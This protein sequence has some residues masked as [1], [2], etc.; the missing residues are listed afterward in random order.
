[1]FKL[2]RFLLPALTDA[3]I[4]RF[5]GGGSDA[6]AQTTTVTSN[7]PEYA[8]PYFE[9]LLGQ[10]EA[11]TGSSNPYTPY[12]GLGAG[13]NRVAGMT[14]QQQ[15]AMQG[16]QNLYNQGTTAAMQTGQSALDS[17]I[18]GT[19]GFQYT[20]TQMGYQNI[21][22]GQLGPQLSGANAAQV[23]AFMSPY[24]QQVVDVEKAAAA[25]D[26]QLAQQGRNAQAVRAGAFGG[27]R[28]AVADAEAQRGLMSQLQSIQAKG[29]QDAFSQAQQALQAERG[30]LMQAGTT[31]LQ[32]S[33]QAAQA[34]QQAYQQAQAAQEQSQQFG[35]TSG[36]QAMQQLGGLGVQLGAMGTQQQQDALALAQAQYGMGQQ[37]QQLTQQQYANAYQ[38]Y[39][40]KLNYPYKQLGFMSDILHG[41]QGVGSASQVY[42]AP[43]STAS[44]VASLGL[45]A[46]GLSSLFGS[47]TGKAGGGKIKK[48]NALKKGRLPAMGM[49]LAQ[50]GLYKALKG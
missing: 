50:A 25:R 47:P 33:L 42:Q 11:L 45:G 13:D 44:Q 23:G 8:Q 26:Y 28:Q 22:A 12:A 36:L 48:P 4:L 9:R 16:V 7:V 21:T 1:M 15:Q 37:Q 38:D 43:P 27:S 41:T 31:N 40:N 35:A 3:F 49:G 19:Q 5:D 32:A 30:A 24:Q 18:Q 17:A 2:F 34:N 14:S 46:Y 39:L 29:S 10:T 6:P 20:P